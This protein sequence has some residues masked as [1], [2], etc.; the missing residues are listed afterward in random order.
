MRKMRK[1]KNW[2]LLVN[3]CFRP[4]EGRKEEAGRYEMRYTIPLMITE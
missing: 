4:G 2:K 1:E 3:Y